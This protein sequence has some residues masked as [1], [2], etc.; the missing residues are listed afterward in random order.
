MTGVTRAV[1]DPAAVCAARGSAAINETNKPNKTS[2]GVT[3]EATEPVAPD[4]ETYFLE[5]IGFLAVAANLV[6]MHLSV[7]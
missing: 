4:T 7:V 6:K 2:A 5:A 3:K 1:S